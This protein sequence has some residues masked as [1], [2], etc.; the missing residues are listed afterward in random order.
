MF[1]TVCWD[2]TRENGFK[3]KEGSFRLDIRKKVFY[4]KCAEALLQVVQRGGGCH[5]S[6]RHSRS[7]WMGL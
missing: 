1:S 6:W 4:N 3:L 2:R 7:G 5:S